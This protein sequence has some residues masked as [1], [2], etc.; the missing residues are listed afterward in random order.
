MRRISEHEVQN[1]ADLMPS[2]P[3]GALNQG[4]LPVGLFSQYWQLAS[5]EHFHLVSNKA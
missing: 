2:V 3:E 1:L 4:V 5:A